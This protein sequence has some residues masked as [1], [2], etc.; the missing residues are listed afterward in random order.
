MFLDRLGKP[1]PGDPAVALDDPEWLFGLDRHPNRL[2]S[3]TTGGSWANHQRPI[4]IEHIASG[5]IQVVWAGKL[6]K[7]V[8][9][10]DLA[11]FG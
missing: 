3:S 8:A 9:N 1:I 10:G 7:P 6:L 5:A 11:I 2:Q 4:G